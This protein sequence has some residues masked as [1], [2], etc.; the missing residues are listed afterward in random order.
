M[1][2]GPEAVKTHPHKYTYINIAIMCE[3][4]AHHASYSVV[5]YH[6]IFNKNY[7]NFR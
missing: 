1:P 5:P 7:T 6:I 3:L 4:P 2:A